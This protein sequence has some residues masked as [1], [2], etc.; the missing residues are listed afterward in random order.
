MMDKDTP[1][2]TPKTENNPKLA[3]WQVKLA[4]RLGMFDAPGVY[5]FALIVDKNGRRRIRLPAEEAEELGR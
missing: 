4:M 3:P 2:L 5:P 1:R